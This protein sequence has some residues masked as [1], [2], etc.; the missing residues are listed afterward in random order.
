MATE[1]TKRLLKI[2]S[3]KFLNNTLNVN[4]ISD[5]NS[6]E[7]F[8][9]IQGEMNSS[10]QMQDFVS[11]IG[12]LL[13]EE[14]LHQIVRSFIEYSYNIIPKNDKNIFMRG[15]TL[16]K[17]LLAFEFARFPKNARAHRQEKLACRVMRM[18]ADPTENIGLTPLKGKNGYVLYNK[19]IYYFNEQGSISAQSKE[20]IS[21]QLEKIQQ[22]FPEQDNELKTVDEE[23]LNTIAIVMDHV[24][25]PLA[26]I[27]QNSFFYI[28][29]MI[30]KPIVEI[31]QKTPPMY[32][33]NDEMIQ[34]IHEVPEEHRYIYDINN[35][36]L[37]YQ[38]LFDTKPQVVKIKNEQKP[39]TIL[40]EKFKTSFQNWPMEIK[41]LRQRFS[42]SNEEY[43]EIKK[44]LVNANFIDNY[45]NSFQPLL[46]HKQ[47]HKK[48]NIA[49]ALGVVIGALGGA[50]SALLIT[51]L[52]GG[53]ALPVL[54]IIGIA[55]GAALVGG[56]VGG[57]IGF[58]AS[59][60]SA[61]K[62]EDICTGSLLKVCS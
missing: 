57:G 37:Y 42:M 21:N 29:T 50:G 2:Y 54:A 59:K 55:V 7:A 43:S 13:S 4:D 27:N 34:G 26:E 61:K 39:Q 30:L 10:G 44:H 58:F 6:A 17:V 8:P 40:P 41:I 62:K 25:S 38:G 28:E 1:N 56:L 31:F 23:D 11:T 20:L 48:T 14:C 32:C 49:C 16:E 5:L 19:T 18:L 36:V 35:H 52:S 15:T 9:P 33:M 47:S 24:Q 51:F 60:Q 53:F 46:P 45:I 22:R 12:E 3:E